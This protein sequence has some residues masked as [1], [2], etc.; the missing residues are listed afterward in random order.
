MFPLSTELV[1]L[2]YD[3]RPNFAFVFSAEI[4]DK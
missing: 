3:F 2:R 4:S 1:L